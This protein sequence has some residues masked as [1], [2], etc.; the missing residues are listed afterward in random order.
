MYDVISGDQ[1]DVKDFH[2]V[3]LKCGAVPLK[4]LEQEIDEYIKEKQ[5]WWSAIF[6]I[7]MILSVFFCLHGLR[8]LLAYDMIYI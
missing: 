7:N 3:V 6:F 2:S 5:K 8:F 1:F 4:F